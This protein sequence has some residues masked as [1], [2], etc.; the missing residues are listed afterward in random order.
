MSEPRPPRRGQADQVRTEHL[1][2]DAQLR[3]SAAIR[4]VITISTRF[5][6]TRSLAPPGSRPV[7]D[8]LIVAGKPIDDRARDA[9]DQELVAAGR[10]EVHAPGAAGDR[11]LHA[12]RQHRLPAEHAIG[13]GPALPA[14]NFAA[15]VPAARALARGRIHR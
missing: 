1:R 6:I 9:P 2:L 11:G 15:I 14:R 10:R 12:H 4:G 7:D 8:E 13:A 5:A 3:R